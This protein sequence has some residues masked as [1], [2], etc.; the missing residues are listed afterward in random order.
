[1]QERHNQKRMVSSDDP[2][3][4]PGQQYRMRGGKK[5]KEYRETVTVQN[6]TPSP[7]ERCRARASWPA[8]AYF[9]IADPRSVS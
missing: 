4:F 2:Q 5:Q 1:M 9:P 7:S 8:R 6:S 3:P